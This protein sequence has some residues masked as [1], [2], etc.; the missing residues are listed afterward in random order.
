MHLAQTRS[1]RILEGSTDLGLIHNPDVNLVI[2]RR[3]VPQ[4]LKDFVDQEVVSLSLN[5]KIEGHSQE[6]ALAALLE[7]VP[8][9]PGYDLLLTDLKYQMELLSGILGRRHM[10]VRFQS[11]NK[12]LCPAFHA[13]KVHVRLICCYHTPATQWLENDQIDRTKLSPHNGGLP[14]E[15]SGLLLPGAQIRQMNPYDVALMKGD[16]W[17]G[18]QGRG[19]V[20]RSPALCGSN[21]RRLLFKI[22]AHGV[23]IS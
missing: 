22:D 2:L 21:A 7:D 5:K 20:H 3:E 18:N 10:T 11:T 1:T 6:L 14:D 13:D 15:S 16:S 19:L 12:T 8:Q 17:P 4:Q 23:D 9:G